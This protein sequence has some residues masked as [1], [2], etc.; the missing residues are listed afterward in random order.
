MSCEELLPVEIALTAAQLPEN[1]LP[2]F[3]VSMQLPLS[4]HLRRAFTLITATPD[5]WN[6]LMESRLTLSI[7][8]DLAHL[9][10]KMEKFTRL[11]LPLKAT[12]AEKRLLAGLMKQCARRGKIPD[13]FDSED[14]AEIKESLEKVCQPRRSEALKKFSRTISE[15]D[16]PPGTKIEIDPSFEHPGVIVHVCI[17]R[18]NLYKL[19]SIEKSLDSLFSRMEIL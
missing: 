14:F 6:D 2:A 17:K 5:I 8:R 18:N 13:S 15:I 1:M 7:L 4:P 11:L 3:C 19:A 12:I 10:E 9:E 16:F